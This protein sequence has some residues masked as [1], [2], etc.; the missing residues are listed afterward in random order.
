VTH[1]NGV[2]CAEEELADAGVV[3]WPIWG[4]MGDPKIGPMKLRPIAS[5]AQRVIWEGKVEAREQQLG[6]GE[7]GPKS[8]LAHPAVPLAGRCGSAQCRGPRIAD[9]EIVRDHRV[10]G[11]GGCVVAVQWSAGRG[12]RRQRPEAGASTRRKMKELSFFVRRSVTQ[13]R[14]VHCAKPKQHTAIFLG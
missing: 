12:A 4:I 6:L 10:Y 1:R 5:V 2:H 13:R 9:V 14:A 7:E 3:G 11:H 8:D